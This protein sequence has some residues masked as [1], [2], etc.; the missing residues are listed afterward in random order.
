[1]APAP[2]E[3]KHSPSSLGVHYCVAE[4]VTTGNAEWPTI[5]GMHA[6]PITVGLSPAT[7][8]ATSDESE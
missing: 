3:T 8:N 1:M 5:S 6:P 2:A 7:A 4:A